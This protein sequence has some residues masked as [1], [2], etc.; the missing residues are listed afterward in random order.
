M[1]I[2]TI[3]RNEHGALAC[4]STAQEGNWP[5]HINA[6][7]NRKTNGALVET[8]LGTEHEERHC[9]NFSEDPQDAVRGK[10]ELAQRN[11]IVKHWIAGENFNLTRTFGYVGQ[12]SAFFYARFGGAITEGRQDEIRNFLVLHWNKLFVGAET[13]NHDALVDALAERFDDTPFRVDQGRLTYRIVRNEIP[14]TPL[15]LSKRT[16]DMIPGEITVDAK[17]KV[18]VTRIEPADTTGNMFTFVIPVGWK[19]TFQMISEATATRILPD[20]TIGKGDETGRE[21]IFE[22][23]TGTFSVTVQKWDEFY[24][25]LD[26]RDRRFMEITFTEED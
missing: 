25:K 11:E 9:I 15:M 10:W 5:N 24:A 3:P 20:R 23:E 16:D 7:K 2:G 17:D 1:S 12:N 13:G 26:N 19:A 21:S 4:Y 6:Y 14:E 8:H 18:R 22:G